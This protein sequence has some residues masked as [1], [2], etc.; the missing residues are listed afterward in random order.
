MCKGVKHFVLKGN[1]CLELFL[2]KALYAAEGRVCDLFKGRGQRGTVGSLYS[3]YNSFYTE[4]SV[5]YVFQLL[6]NEVCLF[7][8]EIVLTDYFSLCEPFS[9]L[10]NKISNEVCFFSIRIVPLVLT[11]YFSLCEPFSINS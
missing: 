3:Q 2:P 1:T 6:S 5:L 8:S 7:L 10:R 4:M 9:A 11:D